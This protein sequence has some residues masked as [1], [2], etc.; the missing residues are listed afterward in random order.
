MHRPSWLAAILILC[1]GLVA[2][3]ETQAELQ[4]E[5]EENPEMTPKAED[6][7][8]NKSDIPWRVFHDEAPIRSGATQ[9]APVVR[10]VARGDEVFGT[11]IEVH[12]ETNEEWLLLDTGP[13]GEQGVYISRSAVH[14]VHPS[15][16]VEGNLPFGEERVDRWWGLPLEYEADDLVEIPGQYTRG[17]RTY[18]L[19]RDAAEALIRMLD[20]A[21]AEEIDIRVTS[22]YRSGM[23]QRDIYLRNIGRRGPGQRSS[24]PPGHSEHQLGTTVDLTDP[25]GQH[26]FSRTFDETPWGAWLE[27]NA[28]RFGFQRSYYPHNIEETGYI[29]EPW[30]WRFI[31]VEKAM[32]EKAGQDEGVAE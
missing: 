9:D 31:G 7:S 10:T 3:A 30:H 29:S 28:V 14:R 21:R 16:E 32:A 27:E 15:N 22:A 2:C 26:T 18:E 6:T 8:F 24:A 4:P 12:P 23:R 5:A 17:E 13:G 25:D 20:E 11:E 19:R 1:A